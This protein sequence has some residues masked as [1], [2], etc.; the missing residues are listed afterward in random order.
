MTSKLNLSI[1]EEIVKRTKRYSRL[2]KISISQLV[3]SYLEELTLTQKKAEANILDKYNGLLN[4]KLGNK[5][6]IE[7]K[8][9]RKSLKYGI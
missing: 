3:Q 6:V 4:G 1:D 8:E 2:N 7:I 5:T 9:K